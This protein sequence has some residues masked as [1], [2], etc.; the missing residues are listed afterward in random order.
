[1]AQEVHSIAIIGGGIAGLCAAVYARK[2][3]FNVDLV[4]QHDTPGGLA[5]RWHRGDYAFETC[6]HW[7]LGSNSGGLL[8][9]MWR[10]VCDIDSL[11]F[12]Y[13]EEF[14]RLETEH[15]DTLRIFADVEKLETELLSVAPVDAEEIRQFAGAIRH[16]TDMPFPDPSA[17][18]SEWGWT[19]LR[20]LP[21][22]PLLW[23][24]SHVSAE[25]YGKRFRHPLLR[26]FFG[27]GG[28]ARMSVLALVFSLAW[29]SVRN[30][31]YPIGG[32]E[33]VI[34]LVADRLANLGGHL[35]CGEKVDR[36]LV[37]DDTA[38]GVRLLSGKTLRADWVISA[39]DGHA[40]VHE[41]L[42]GRYRDASVD[43][44]FDNYET[45]PSYL[46]V[47]LGVAF[48]LS[49]K[50]GFL[51]MVLDTPLKVDPE[52]SLEQISFRLFHYDPTC[53][54]AGK[55]AVTCFLPT[56]NFG[57]WTGLRQDDP[58][59]YTAEK[60]RVAEAAIAILEGRISNIR[61]AIEIIDI[62]TPAT[63][64]RYTG[65]WKGSMEGWLMTPA[66]GFGGLPQTLPGLDRFL[67]IGQWAQ[68]G[69][70]LPGGLMT[71]RA[72]LKT[73]CRHHQVPFARE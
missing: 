3:G 1:M 59:R 25:D 73:I 27:E 61:Q 45:F 67:R 22:M 7:L 60:N 35:R 66:T 16:L 38:V 56:P 46:Q 62:S 2:C 64:I 33:A 71:A 13:R 44:V 31:G 14:L 48:D 47:S 4:E 30:A 55:T 15:G 53:A 8:H 52:T 19:M 51:T 20:M 37:E 36:I 10:E 11:H 24:L 50:P 21:D 58:D 34:G 72:A 43:R 41:L 6:L 26:R 9:D 5:A 29:Q 42:E 65:N 32:S 28:T 68:P 23:R 54:P 57:Y 39:A 40:T 70:G 17:T 18:W 69:G 49:D 12:L 63:V